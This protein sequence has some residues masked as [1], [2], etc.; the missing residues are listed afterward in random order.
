[1]DT[2]S[3]KVNTS[4]TTFLVLLSSILQAWPSIYLKEH[5]RKEIYPEIYVYLISL[6]PGHLQS[7]HRTSGSVV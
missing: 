2:Q 4:E 5:P 1:M 6:I 3:F 7:S